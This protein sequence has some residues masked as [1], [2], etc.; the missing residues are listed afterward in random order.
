MSYFFK[1][2]NLLML[3]ILSMISLL[4]VNLAIAEVAV[5]VHPSNTSDFD[6]SIIKKMFLG[7]QKSFSNGRTAIMLSVSNTDPVMTEFNQKVMDKSNSQIKAYWSK[8]IF[9]GK[10]TPPQ[11]MPSASEVIS[12]VSTNPDSIGYIDAAAATDAV[13]VV[14]TF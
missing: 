7:K 4:T 14:A 11:E 8:I 13:R 12:S 2:T 10:G 1:K 3:L 9:T 5:I 6:Q